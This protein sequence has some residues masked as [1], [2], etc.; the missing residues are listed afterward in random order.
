MPE[1]KDRGNRAMEEVL[2]R[3]EEDK[4]K[5]KEEAARFQDFSRQMKHS[6]SQMNKLDRQLNVLTNKSYK[7]PPKPKTPLE[8]IR[9]HVYDYLKLLKSKGDLRD[10]DKDEQTVIHMCIRLV[11][12][13]DWIISNKGGLRRESKKTRR[14]KPKKK[15]PKKKRTKR[16]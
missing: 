5:N 3:D 4:A 2:R 12:Y 16:S 6:S 14:K 7:T 1:L 8:G 9:G 15:K 10:K 11:K 13:I